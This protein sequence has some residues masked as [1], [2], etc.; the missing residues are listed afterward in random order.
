MLTTKLETDDANILVSTWP[1]NA[2]EKPE[3]REEK[4][5]LAQLTR[6]ELPESVT[7]EWLKD[8]LCKMH[9]LL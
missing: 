7:K 5:L 1:H 4:V 3:D 9:G 2:K 8:G 6:L